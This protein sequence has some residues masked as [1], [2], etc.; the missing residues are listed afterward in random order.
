METLHS[1]TSIVWDFSPR[2]L[3]LADCIFTP[4]SFALMVMVIVV[5]CNREL[6]SAR[7]KPC[8]GTCWV[9]STA[10]CGVEM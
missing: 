8:L 1:R 5:V 2:W 4:S 6:D 7:K 10:G 9:Q 3:P